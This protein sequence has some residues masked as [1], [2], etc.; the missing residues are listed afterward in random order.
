MSNEYHWLYNGDEYYGALIS[1]LAQARISIRL[2]MYIFAAGG[3]GDAVRDALVAAAGRGV[4]VRVLIDAFGSVALPSDYWSALL[5][6]GGHYR[7]FNP[8]NLGRITFRD[9]RK[10]V[11]CDDRLALVGGFNI[12]GD[13][14]GDGIAHGW[15]D[16][17]LRI[18]GP[19]TSELGASFDRMYDMAEFRHP[20]LMR[21]RRPRVRRS[22]PGIA[23][24]AALLTSYPGAMSSP[25]KESLVSDLR[26]ARTIRIISAYFLPTRR[27]NRVLCQNARRGGDVQI[28]TAGKTDVRLARLAGRA[29]YGRFLRAGI[30]VFEYQPQILHAKLIVADNV[31]YVGSVNL[32]IRSLNINYELLVRIDDVHLASEAERLFQSYLPHCREIGQAEWATSRSLWEK[33]TERIAFVILARFDARLARRQLK[34]LN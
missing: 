14:A 16:L 17:G 2:E 25:I 11:V 5:A 8:L 3:P 27:L 1:A 15:R 19:L 4:D 29:M 30:R 24:Q 12:S 20:R 34:L 21:M 31:V 18:Y 13:Q 28:I 6:A 33:I 23:A 10:L 7:S 32:D 26:R 9:H 22:V